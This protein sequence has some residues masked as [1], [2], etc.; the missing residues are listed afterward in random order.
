MYPRYRKPYSNFSAM[1]QMFCFPPQH[2][3]GNDV[4]LLLIPTVSVSTEIEC[5]V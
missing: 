1:Q 3:G 5:T 4:A 2:E